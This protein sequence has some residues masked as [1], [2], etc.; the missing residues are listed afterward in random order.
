MAEY[1]LSAPEKLDRTFFVNR[2]GNPLTRAGAAYILNKYVQMAGVDT[3]VSPHVLRHPYVKPE[4]QIFTSF[5]VYVLP[6]YALYTTKG[7]GQ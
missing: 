6:L 1:G 4:T 7:I 3:H 5:G 2:Q